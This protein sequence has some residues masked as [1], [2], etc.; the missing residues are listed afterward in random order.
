MGSRA[1]KSTDSLTLVENVRHRLVNLAQSTNFVRDE[2]VAAA[3]RN[4]WAGPGGE[5]GLVSEL[6]VEGAFTSESSGDTLQ[7]LADSLIVDRALVDHLDRSGVFPARRPLYR[8]QADA[9]RRASSSDDQRPALIVSAGTGAGKTEAFLLPILNDLWRNPRTTDR[10]GMRCLLLYPMNA[11]VADQVERVAEWLKDNGKGLRVFHFTSETP[12]DDRERAHR[13]EPKSTPWRVRTRQEARADPPDIVITNYSMLEYMLCRPQ[14]NPFFGPGLRAIVLDEAHLYAGVLAAEITMLLR[15]VRLRCGVEAEH[16]LQIATSATLGGEPQDLE[17]FAATV[18]SAKTK[19]TVGVFGQ[20]AKPSFSAD[21]DS[22]APDPNPALMAK[23]AG[24]ELRTLTAD[25]QFTDDPPEARQSLRN[26]LRVLLSEQVVSEADSHSPK[27]AGPF[28]HAAL[29]RSRL[30]RQAAEKLH[31]VDGA[32]ALTKLAKVLFSQDTEESQRATIALLRL[33]AS[34]RQKADAPPLIPHRLHFLAR[35]PESLCACLNPDCKGPIERRLPGIGCLQPL[36]EKCRYC[37]SA[38][39]AVH[40]CDVCGQ[41]ALAAWESAM[42][43][44]QLPLAE[45]RQERRYLLTE[46]VG[47]QGLNSTIV[48]PNDGEQLGDGSAGLRL[49]VAPCPEHGTECLDSSK[50]RLQSCPRCGVR[51]SVRNNSDEDDRPM[52]LECKP[53]RGSESLA[54]SVLAETLLEGMSVFPDDSRHW[55]PANGRRLLCFSD[56]R[57]EAARLGPQLTR[58]HERLLIRAAIADAAKELGT[59]DLASFLEGQI[60][61]LNRRL[62]DAGVSEAARINIERQLRDRRAELTQARVGMSFPDF[63]ELVSKDDRVG[64]IFDRDSGERHRADTWNQ[65][66]WSANR[67][68]VAKRVEALVATELNRRLPTKFSL[69]SAGFVEVSYPNLDQVPPPPELLG[70]LPSQ[71]LRDTIARVWP[72]YLAALLDSLRFDGAAGWSEGDSVRPEH[73]WDDDSPLLNRWTARDGSGWRSV[74]FVGGTDRQLRRWFTSLVLDRAGCSSEK[75]RELAVDMLSAAFDSLFRSALD[76]Q[77]PWLNAEPALQLDQ[78]GRNDKALKI[79]LDG[80][81]VRRPSRLFACPDSLTLWP[82]TVLGWAPLDGCRGRL[83]DAHSEAQDALRRW[84]RERDELG[85]SVFR[86][87]LW[88][89]EHSAQLDAVD[90]R[91]LQDLFKAGVRNILS[92]TTTMELGIDIGGLNGVLLGNTPPGPA[93]HRQRAGRA[94]RRADGSSV[95]STFAQA[96]PFD[97]EVFGRFG[98]F[99]AQPFRRPVAH[100]DRERIVRR[101][102]HA[103]LLGEFFRREGLQRPETG[104]MD[105]YSWMGQFCRSRLPPRWGDERSKPV[106]PKLEGEA[107]DK[108][109]RRWLEAS[110]DLPDDLYRLV[111]AL[112]RG[113]TLEGRVREPSGWRALL[114]ETTVQ[115]ENAVDS[116]RK[117]IKTLQAAWDAIEKSPSGEMLNRARNEANA[118]RYQIKLLAETTVIEWLADHRFLPRYGFPI[119]LQRLEVRRPD[120]K[121][122]DRSRRDERFRLE[123]SSLLALAEYVPGAKVLAGGKTATSRGLLKYWTETTADRALGRGEFLIKCAADHFYLSLEK[124]RKCPECQSEPASHH[125]LLF[126]RYGYL[127]A[128]WEPPTRRMDLERV[129]EA[130][131][132]PIEAFLGQ[133]APLIATS[134]GEV[135][136]LVASY[137]EESEVLLRNEGEHHTGFAICTRCGFAMSERS[138]GK[139]K[140]GLP[141]KFT[142]H[143]PVFQ[144]ADRPWCWRKTEAPVLRNRTLAARERTDLLTLE[145]PVTTKAD[146]SAVV[147]LGRALV[148]AG[149]RLLEVDSRELEARPKRSTSGDSFDLI[150]FDSG[151]SGAG[152]CRELFEVGEEWFLR[153]KGILQGDARHDSRCERACLDCILDFS[154]Q[155]SASKLDRK[156]ALML[157]G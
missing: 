103:L 47:E 35:A 100:L 94:G 83:T 130:E 30:V 114:A 75:A 27:Q 154:G 10:C 38:T 81:S 139:G 77:L 46:D 147:S 7:S 85:E 20:K 133:S 107:L 32:V 136:G 150:L 121:R 5:G 6:W 118:I 108:R 22:A 122:S 93:N 14:D 66:A 67:R 51:W 152:H 21:L 59:E 148:M 12:N 132:Y 142:S 2:R 116:W 134:F 125:V 34:A 8:H 11:L 25:G 104:A 28:L 140:D 29:S 60:D 57:R 68:E 58:Q 64:Q 1:A 155:F 153:A 117:D 88:G 149:T 98:T 87:G 144:A 82:R 111:N 123:R 141:H 119:N 97:R 92:S 69:E 18:F 112:S 49:F 84:S 101:H 157:L 17:D 23:H 124:D 151:S 105:A 95:V 126:P 143:A 146:E 52:D 156:A 43:Q 13:G 89:E 65:L 3:C 71:D 113:T 63:A 102:V 4:V 86:T 16:L 131:L 56:S 41:W 9:L 78:K 39:L 120:P 15:R 19:N 127:T 40:R 79:L 76:D 135:S 72:D 50:C 55:K 73:L 99:L 74:R 61:D 31:E 128:A 36:S 91:R 129:G 33:C 45:E 26:A 70:T 42:M 54:R 80:L 96:R 24:I 137:Y 90:N 62:S 138:V 53:L 109:F 48:D 106:R 110:D 115:F 44:L 145:F 37:R